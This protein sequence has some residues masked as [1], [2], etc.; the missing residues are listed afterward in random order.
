MRMPF[1]PLV[2]ALLGLATSL[3]AQR[4][5]RDTSIAI[6]VVSAGYSY[7]LPGGDMAIRFGANSNINLHAARKFKSN[8]LLGVEGAF[9]FG[10][11]VR[12][13]GLL[14]NIITREGQIVDETGEM[15]DVFLYERGWSAFVVAGKIMPVAGPNPNSG[16]M[17]KFGL[18]YLRHKIRIQTQSNEVPQLQGDYLEGYDRLS[19]GPAAM[20]FIGYQ[21]FSNRGRINF[22]VGFEMI[23]GFIQPLRAYNF[24]IERADTDTRFDALNGLRAGW[25]LP[26]Y[27]KRDDRF[28]FW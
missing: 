21:N 14:K 16:M 26:I 9:L 8:Y 18:G 28:H 25:S 6:T 7:Q 2:L 4:S 12:E 24:D 27:K 20:L 19:G 3:H 15:A 5:I 13:P 22:F 1:L 23:A 17:L 10:D 11:N